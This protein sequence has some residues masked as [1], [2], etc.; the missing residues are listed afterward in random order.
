MS[1][2]WIQKLRQMRA[3][4][5]EPPVVEP[6]TMPPP[7]FLDLVRRAK[8]AE[9]E[10]PA[11]WAKCPLCLGYIVFY[12]MGDVWR[13]VNNRGTCH[14]CG[15]QLHKGLETGMIP[16]GKLMIWDEQSA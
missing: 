5:N 1:A 15:Y 11:E 13:Y 16:R 14:H 8:A 3:N 12:N 2:K 6:L 10:R 4:G 7:N 9:K